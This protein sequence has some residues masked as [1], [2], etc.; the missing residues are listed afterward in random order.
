MHNYLRCLM[1]V[2]IIVLYIFK[3]Y[4]LPLPVVAMAHLS[5]FATKLYSITYAQLVHN[6]FHYLMPLIIIK[7]CLSIILIL[8]PIHIQAHNILGMV[9]TV[10]VCNIHMNHTKYICI[11][12]SRKQQFIKSKQHCN[13]SF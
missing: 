10:S 8:M 5:F 3:Y 9:S 1:P 13:G 6:N 2:L 12:I 11:R 7:Y 4:I